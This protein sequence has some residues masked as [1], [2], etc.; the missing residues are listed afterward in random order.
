MNEKKDY[1][2]QLA[3]MQNQISAMQ[4]EMTMVEDEHGDEE[5]D[6]NL[7][8]S[9]ELT[10]EVDYEKQDKMA[11]KKMLISKMIAQES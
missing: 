1:A 2:K 11:K 10:G 7:G 6:G 3:D 5:Q 9:Q 4:K 8:A